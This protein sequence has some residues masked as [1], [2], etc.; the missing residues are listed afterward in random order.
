MCR[1]TPMPYQNQYNNAALHQCCTRF[2]RL[3][4][5]HQNK[6][7]T[8]TNSY[9]NIMN[10]CAR[11]SIHLYNHQRTKITLVPQSVR[12]PIN[13]LFKLLWY[14]ARSQTDLAKGYKGYKYHHMGWAV[15]VPRLGLHPWDWY[16]VS[17]HDT[18][19][20]TAQNIVRSDSWFLVILS[21]ISKLRMH[22]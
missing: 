12:K 10:T 3:M 8:C 20:D 16:G 21:W 11:M 6:C 13:A 18:R 7:C 14:L 5:Y 9:Q 22:L 1:N 2:S 4:L 19:T 15:S 17:G